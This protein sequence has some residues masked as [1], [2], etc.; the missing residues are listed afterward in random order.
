MLEEKLSYFINE[1]KKLKES[2]F[3]KVSRIAVIGSF[4][5]NGLAE[6]LQVKCAKSNIF[7][8]IFSGGY[9]R[10]N[11][12]ILNSNSDLYSFNPEICFLILDTRTILEDLFYSTYDVTENDRRIFVNKKFEEISNLIKFYTNKSKSKI[13]FSNFVPPT[14]SS[15]GIFESK[16]EYGLQE[17]IHDLNQKLSNE[18]KNDPLTFL[19]NFNGFVTNHGLNTVFDYRQYYLGDVKISLEKIP[20]LAN[21]LMGYVKPILGINK[22]CIVLDL[23]NTL[24]GGIIGE[25][26]FN[27]IKLGHND[28]IGKSFIE[29]QKHLLSLHKRGIILAVNSKN[30]YEDAM[31]VIKEHPNMILR[32][33]NFACLKINWNDKSRNLREIS[34]EVNIGLDSIVFFDDDKVNRDF[35]ISVLPEV[36]TVEMPKDPSQYVPTLLE[37]T[38]FN[39]LKITEEDKSRGKMYREQRKRTELE[40]STNDFDEYLKQLNI[41]LFIKNADEFT[42]PRI[43]QLTLKTNQFN[44]TTKRYQEEDIRN[45]S[46]DDKKIIGCARVEDKFGD[47]GITGVFIVDKNNKEWIIDTFLLSC[48]IIGRGIEQGIINYIISLAKKENVSKLTANF[49][50]TKKNQPAESFLPSFGFKKLNDQWVYQIENHIDS[51]TSHLHIS[52]EE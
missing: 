20:Y 38:D 45:F 15:Y 16:I 25:D 31:K 39:V 11:E 24:W 40:K 48:R 22:K 21:E 18:F 8:H 35:I 23:D 37:L 27:G 29:F 17:M 42:I 51:T 36:L 9:N 28:P 13:I 2:D 33:E 34:Q 7:S 19:Y 30:N 47:N 4:T 3:E 12:E 10:Y 14:Y 1:S 49:I 44:L 6:T 26:G 5:L 52:K 41:K 43:S 46:Q 50:P 32:E